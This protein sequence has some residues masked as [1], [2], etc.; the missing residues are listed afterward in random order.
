[1][2]SN[3]FFSQYKR[4]ALGKVS[5]SAFAYWVLVHADEMEPLLDPDEWDLYLDA[6]IVA[7]EFS[8]G[9]IDETRARQRLL[10]LPADHR[11]SPSSLG[12]DKHAHLAQARP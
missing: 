6:E 9:E 1:M 8:S 2:A 4:F 11:I 12:L 7:A 10:E 5:A 3:A